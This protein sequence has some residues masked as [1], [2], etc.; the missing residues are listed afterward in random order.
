MIKTSIGKLPV[1]WSFTEFIEDHVLGNDFL[2]LP[3]ETV[4]LSVLESLP[5]H[6]RDP[7]DR[8]IIAQAIVEDL[9]A[10][11]ADSAFKSY[12]VDLHL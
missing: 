6:H 3:V 7:F 5:H 1:S 2:I 8:M 10:T 4:H 11:G 12:D 9:V